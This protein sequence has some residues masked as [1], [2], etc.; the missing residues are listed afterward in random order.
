MANAETPSDRKRRRPLLWWSAGVLGVLLVLVAIFLA[1]F[2]WN[3]LQGPIATYASAKIGRPVRIEGNLRVHL[4]SA[5]PLATAD[6]VRVGNPAWM[7]TGGDLVDIGRLTIEV[8]AWPLLHGE[9]ELP[10]IQIDRPA[11]RLFRNAKGRENWNFGGGAFRPPPI[12][13][14]V[15]RDG[16]LTLNDE[17]RPMTLQGSLQ[18]S[19]TDLGSGAGAFEFVGGGTIRGQPFQATVHGGPLIDVRRDRPYPFAAIVNAGASHIIA[20]GVLPKPF[21]LDQISARLAVKGH[22]LYDLYGLT[23]LALPNTPPFH[24]DTDMRRDGTRFDFK[25][26]A[27]VIGSSDLEGD[28]ALTRDDDRPDLTADLRSRRADARDLS[29]LL[30]APPK[31]RERSVAQAADAAHLA[32]AGRLLP[33]ATLN[34]SRVRSMDAHVRYK[35]QSVQATPN[36]PLRQFAIDLTLDHGV[37]TADPLTFAFPHGALAGTVRLDARGEVPDTGVDLRVTGVRAEDFFR[38]GKAP[39]VTGLIEARAKLNGRGN[40]VHAAASNAD[41]VVSVVAPQGQIRKA[42]AELTGIDLLNGLG[43]LLAKNESQTG[44]RCAVADFHA[45]GG[46]LMARNIVLD[47][48]PVLDTGHGTINLRDETLNLQLQGKPKKFRVLRVVAPITLSGHIRSPKI[49]IK[50]GKAPLQVA[51]AV[52][53]GAILGPL[54]AVIPFVDPGLAKNADCAALIGHAKA[55]GAPVKAPP[56]L[57]RRA[58]R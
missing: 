9:V 44:V 31:P 19:Q 11:L 40:S 55:E 22:D 5:E 37:M 7:R 13:R 50:A 25:H 49:G 47:T 57:A 3:M 15:I 36:L 42:L 58:S 38:P 8:K 32:A 54:A 39:P 16:R 18:S 21:D 53:A 26:L 24:L 17:K 43:L 41:G 29:T 10:L 52:A 46:V 51:A 48:D 56:A 20:H 4:W 12:Q 28:L 45:Q 1:V 14:L 33:D 30:G 2:N 34:V 23:G 6:D 35:A 27:G